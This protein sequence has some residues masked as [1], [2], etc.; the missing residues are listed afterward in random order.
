[1]INILLYKQ[2]IHLLI[3]ELI[4]K[5]TQKLIK[6]IQ[7]HKFLFCNAEAQNLDSKWNSMEKNKETNLLYSLLIIN[8]FITLLLSESYL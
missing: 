1:M 4:R 3:F 6:K 2:F 7:I 8:I 5:S